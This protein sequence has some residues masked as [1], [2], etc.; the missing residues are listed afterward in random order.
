MIPKDRHQVENF[1]AILMLVVTVSLGIYLAIV[2][3]LSSKL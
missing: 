3:Y 1:F 2:L